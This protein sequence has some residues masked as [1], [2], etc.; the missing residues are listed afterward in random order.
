[1]LNKGSFICKMILFHFIQCE[2]NHVRSH[3]LRWLAK[4]FA[5]HSGP[6]S[7]GGLLLPKEEQS[8][9]PLLEVKLLLY[10]LQSQLHRN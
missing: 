6:P 4:T 8:F 2:G 1:M 10:S 3:E 9:S 5:R 7:R